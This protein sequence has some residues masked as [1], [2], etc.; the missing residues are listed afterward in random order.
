MYQAFYAP[1][2]LLKALYRQLIILA[3]MFGL[4]AWIFMFYE[5]ASPLIAL[6]ASVSTITTIGLFVPHGGDFAAMSPQETVLLILVIIGSVGAAA[7][8]LQATVNVVVNGGLARG[9]AEKRL[10]KRMKNHVIVFG[11]AQLGRYV[12]DK[13][14]ELGIDYTVVTHEPAIYDSLTKKKVLTVLHHENRPI[15]ALQE[16]GIKEA[17]TL[18]AAHEKDPENILIILSAR[19]LRPDIRIVSVVHDEQLI[20]TAK[21]AG[22]DVTVPSSVSVG[23]LLA[24]SAI[25]RDLVGIVFSEKVGTK[26]IAQ[27]SVFK[28]SKLIGKKLQD[29]TSLAQVIGLVRNQQLVQNV[30]DPDLRISED[31]TL[32]VFGDPAGLHELETEAEAL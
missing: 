31:D 13:L 3:A 10:L 29:V 15:V 25:T 12:A 28:S 2:Y 19:R 23:H 21:N 18:I 9:E 17:S 32:L 26:E 20:E 16:A 1:L 14:G 22:A 24:L 11:Y 8:F 4:G 5:H 6:F 30:F 7:S 27:F